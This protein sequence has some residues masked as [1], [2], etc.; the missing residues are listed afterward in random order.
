M[1]VIHLSI[2]GNSSIT[3]H[4]LEFPIDFFVISG[5]G[6]INISGKSIEVNENDLI[7]VEPNIE[8]AWTNNDSSPLNIIGIK[9]KF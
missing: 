8:R 2:K 7:S 9:N 1:E 4:T 5:K 6:I 3:K